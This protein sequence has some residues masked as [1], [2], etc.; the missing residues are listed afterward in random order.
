MRASDRS[1]RIALV[2]GL[3]VPTVLLLPVMPV[4]ASAP[5]PETRS[6][7]I[8]DVT[9]RLAATHPGDPDASA[10]TQ[11]AGDQRRTTEP[12]ETPIP[13]VGL[14]V[15]GRGEEPVLRV[16]TRDLDGQWSDWTSVEL[17]DELEGP[18]ADSA[19]GA[20][21]PGSDATWF[22]DAIWAGPSS[23]VQLEVSAGA[24]DDIEIVVT[25]TAGLSE[26]ITQRLVRWA[27]SL[28]SG[29]PAQAN[30]TPPGAPDIETRSDWGADESWRSGTPI[31]REVEHAVLHHTATKNDYTPEEAPQQI[32]NIYNW[33]TNHLGWNDIGYNFLVD[34]FGTIYEG[35]YGGMDKGIQGAHAAGWNAGSFGVALLGNYNDATPSSEGL[36][37][38]IDLMAWKYG[39]HGLDPDPEARVSRNDE[40][41]RTLEGHRNLRSQYVEWSDSD[42]FRT[43]C[44]GERLYWQMSNL[45]DG[46][47]QRAEQAFTDVSTDHPFHEEIA[48]V[49]ASGIASGYTDGTFRPTR[50]VSRM[51]VTAFLHRTAGE[52]AGPHPDPGY[53]DVGDDHPFRDEI[54]WATDAGIVTGYADGTFRPGAAVTRQATAAFLYR[55]ER[56]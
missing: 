16:R 44:P 17:L 27:G 38:L 26:S 45:R 42:S 9:E 32:R 50:D 48:W 11:P 33:H 56:P 22:S 14:G 36:A 3:L 4:G 20:A 23:H 10:T 47:E 15:K 1:L 19:E 43:D 30:E 29:Q 31:E 54:A 55:L 53:D 39:V 6:A 8:D 7:S 41:I 5:V 28:G 34:R 2:L 24:P 21:A 25:D 35:R 52:P 13:F 51:A 18:D 12:I 37:S 49:A 46:I 40:Q